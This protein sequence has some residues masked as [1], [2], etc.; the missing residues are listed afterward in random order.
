MLENLIS[1]PLQ[2]TEIAHNMY[3]APVT[4]ATIFKGKPPL[5]F[6]EERVRQI[7]SANPWLASRLVDNEQTGKPSLIHAE[8]PPLYPFYEQVEIADICATGTTV[9][10]ILAETYAMPL[11]KSMSQIYTKHG[12]NSLNSDEPLYKIR[13][14]TGSDDRFMLVVS[15]SHV[16]GDGF[17]IYRIYQMLERSEPVVAL[18]PQRIKNFQNILNTTGGLPG[19]MWIPKAG[20]PSTPNKKLDWLLES[21]AIWCTKKTRE[22]IGMKHGEEEDIPEQ[23]FQT[24]GGLFRVN[25]DWVA[26]QKRN[27]K[28]NETI[29]WIST[30][31]VISSWFLTRSNTSMGSI[32]IN[33]RDRSPEVGM[34][35]AG[36]YQVGFLLYPDEYESPAA[37]RASVGSFS[38]FTK[39]ESK[40]GAGNSL[41]LISSWTQSYIDLDFGPECSQLIHLPLAPEALSPPTSMDSIMILFCCG[42]GELAAAIRSTNISNYLDGTA[43]QGPLLG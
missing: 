12:F 29:P 23:E 40:A 1:I 31:D 41:A 7:L 21:R 28:G 3:D 25:R 15:M 16:L 2:D 10:A 39:P 4:I 27:F 30:N 34:L 19:S 43:L 11:S 13:L 35:H 42:N 32:A 8:N 36:N 26:E 20:T 14:C 37:I 18:I 6:L 22:A 24:S 38:S 5:G 17:T 33:S 9:D